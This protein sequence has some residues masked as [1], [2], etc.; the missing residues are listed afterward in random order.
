VLIAGVALYGIAVT[1]LWALQRDLMY[2]PDHAPRVPPSH[3]AMLGGVQEV[4][5]TTADGVELAA[6][7]AAAP[8]AR[9]TVVMF[10]GN[11]GSL[12]H[13]RY[14]LQHFMDAGLGAM[15]LSYRGYSGNGGTPTEEGLYADAR[16]ALDWLD[17]NGVDDESIVVYGIS[18]GTGVATK[19]AAERELG[20]VVLEAPYTS[21]VDVA[22]IRFPV[23][24]VGWLMEDRFESLARIRA[25]TEP[26]LVMHGDRDDVIPQ[27][28]GRQLFDAANAPKE[29]FWPT[30]VGHSDVFDNGG[31]AVAV[32]FIRR[33]MT[34]PADARRAGGRGG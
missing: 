10:H 32:E 12:R 14:R 26:L 28:F 23:V 9:P 6:W 29:G 25:I 5:V 8:P 1:A 20:A 11:A 7:Y 33:T 13:E 19:M 17:A 16:A 34:V 27:R 30:G 4:L 2:F 18:L 22:G 15:L 24:P 21:T 31:F 3:Y